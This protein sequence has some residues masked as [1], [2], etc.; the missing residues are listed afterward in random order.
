MSLE[1]VS[2]EILEELPVR[3]PRETKRF[4]VPLART[5]PT[6]R[7][8][9]SKI[10]DI[11]KL[12]D[13]TNWT[14]TVISITSL[15]LIIS[16]FSLFMLNNNQNSMFFVGLIGS[17]MSLGIKAHLLLKI[18]ENKE[19]VIGTMITRQC[20]YYMTSLTYERTYYGKYFG[21]FSVFSSVV[22]LVEDSTMQKQLG[23][24]L[25][26]EVLVLV[27]VLTMLSQG[28]TLS[29]EENKVQ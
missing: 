28:K 15:F 20:L 22:N 26:S 9:K 13:V 17:I 8:L 19:S 16:I 18:R 5:S 24:V 1:V 14:L 11:F 27:S 12:K 25:F 7:M 4:R 23:W 21:G 2:E 10:S 6:S 3:A 29:K